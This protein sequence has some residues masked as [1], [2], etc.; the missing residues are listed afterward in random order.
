MP[1]ERIHQLTT[2]E[3]VKYILLSVPNMV[4]EAQ[5]S[6]VNCADFKSYK[7]LS[8]VGVAGILKVA[9]TSGVAHKRHQSFN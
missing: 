9:A 8:P 7:K 3:V 6:D 4:A 1:T 2:S 5:F